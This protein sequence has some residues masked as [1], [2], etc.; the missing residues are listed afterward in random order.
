MLYSSLITVALE[1]HPAPADISERV[2]DVR[3]GET[4]E[5]RFADQTLGIVS[6]SDGEFLWRCAGRWEMQSTGAEIYNPQ[7]RQD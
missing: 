2:D 4:S 6:Y 1:E 3:M 7:A 5:N